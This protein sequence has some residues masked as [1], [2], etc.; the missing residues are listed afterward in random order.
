MGE[1]KRRHLAKL[2]APCVCGSDKSASGCCWT[3][4]GWRRAASK[5]D[6][7]NTGFEGRQERCYLRNLGT[8][9]DTMSGEHS[10]SS[11]VLED[12]GKDEV[13]VTGMPWL[14]AGETRQIPIKRLV[15]N[16]LCVAHNRALSP[17]DAAAGRF[18]RGLRGCLDDASGMTKHHLVS[19]FDIE[20][21]LL[22]IVAGLAASKS[23]AADGRRLENLFSSHVA[24]AELMQDPDKW[25]K[26]MGLY[27]LQQTGE[28]FQAS[29]T[30]ELAPL[31]SNSGH[32]GGLVSRL[33]GVMICLLLDRP[34]SLKGSSLERATYRLT[35]FHVRWPSGTRLLELSW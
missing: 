5:I 12:I 11:T 13:L 18:Y 16:C 20:R 7:I 1:A 2:N 24:I 6:L 21:W 14:A 23:L 29:N 33:Q 10:I 22:K 8:C 30:L 34:E 35:K 28:Q 19:G 15:A 25:V 31:H 32:I 27:Y 3:E 17:L 26:P 4:K 9:C